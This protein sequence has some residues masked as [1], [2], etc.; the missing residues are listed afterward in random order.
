MTQKKSQ[1]ILHTEMRIIYMVMQCLDFFQQ[2]HS[3]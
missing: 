3:N 2:V 1:N